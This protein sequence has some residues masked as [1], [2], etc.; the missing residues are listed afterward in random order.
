VAPTN[1]A[2][3]EIEAMTNKPQI[4]FPRRLLNERQVGEC[5]RSFTFPMEVDA[6]GMKANLVNGLL[7]IVVPKKVDA[8]N[9][10]RSIDIE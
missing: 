10:T 3:V 1:P 5:Q 9:T 7:R 6:D 2:K 8:P 4:H